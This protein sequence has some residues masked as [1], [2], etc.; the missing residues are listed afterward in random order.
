MSRFAKFLAKRFKVIEDSMGIPSIINVDGF[1]KSLV[2]SF[3]RVRMKHAMI[4]FLVEKVALTE[5]D[6]MVQ[7]EIYVENRYKE[8]MDFVMKM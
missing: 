6:A 5:S 8:Y 3:D 7:A 4:Y 2:L 1:D